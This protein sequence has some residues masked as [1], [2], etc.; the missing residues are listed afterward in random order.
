[1]LEFL[2]T[3]IAAFIIA[4]IINLLRIAIF[5]NGDYTRLISPSGI[6]N[7]D[8]QEIENRR[9]VSE[10]NT[11][12]IKSNNPEINQNSGIIEI[13]TEDFMCFNNLSKNEILNLRRNAV[14]T[15]PV[16]SNM[17]YEPNPNVFGIGD[18][19]PWISTEGALHFNKISKEKRI[20]GPSRDS[21]G[22]LNPELL[23]YVSIAENEDVENTNFKTLYKD[24][25]FAPY[26]VTYDS[27]TNTITAYIK[28]E[29]KEGNYQPLFLSDSNAH[30]LGYNYAIMD[31][32]KNIGFYSDSPYKESTLKSD[33]QSITGYYM[34]GSACGIED[35]CNNYAPY[36]Q[37]Y[38]HLYI[39]RLPAWFNIKLWKNKPA[40]TEQT[41]DINYKMVFE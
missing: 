8:I 24:F 35:G 3:V 28:N 16:F 18:Y 34:I 40:N 20:I 12:Q 17:S 39:K 9:N 32:S 21:I 23:Y 37:Y 15:S 13:S 10:Q 41:P 29:H 6:L 5:E 2:R 36:W 31:L 30:D 19:K 1:M 7:N 14:S 27:D 25:Y 11:V 22:I 26:K 38:N 33:I 4:F